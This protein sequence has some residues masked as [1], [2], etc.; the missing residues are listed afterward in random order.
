M[1]RKI[2]SVGIVLALSAGVV[3]ADQFGALITKV[4]GDNV[5]FYPFEGKGKDAKKGDEKTMKVAKDVKIVQGKF[6]KETKKFEA[7]DEIEGGLKHKMF[8]EI[9]E[10][11]IFAFV[12]T[13]DDNKSI[14]EIRVF[15]PKKGKKQ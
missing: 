15:L 7:G 11:G 6:N 12:N 9:S 2:V 5:T 14:K 13:D 4:E 3:F 8:Q 10:K 1:L